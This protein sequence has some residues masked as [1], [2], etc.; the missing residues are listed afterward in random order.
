MPPYVI[1]YKAHLLPE[2]RRRREAARVLARMVVGSVHDLARELAHALDEDDGEMRRWVR[3][4]VRATGHASLTPKAARS[5]AA[6]HGDP[7]AL[8]CQ[9]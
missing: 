9:H 1:W 6:G 7:H 5:L 3:D 2:L 8:F 4:A